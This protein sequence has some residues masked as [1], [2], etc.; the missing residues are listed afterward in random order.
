MMD[1][2]G[3]YRDGT[4]LGD[5]LPKVRALRDRYSRVKVEDK[6]TVFNT[7][8]LEAREVGY[9]LD[10]AETTVV[11]AIA[12]KESRGAHAREDYPDRDDANFLSHS[13]AFPAEDGPTLR[14]KPVTITR[15]EPKPRTY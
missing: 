14:Y 15:F 4:T 6:G 5:A 8:L 9:L 7:D 10:C 12:R 11:A 2:V 1:G 3:V 13:L